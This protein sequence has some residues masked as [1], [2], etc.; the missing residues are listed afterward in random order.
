MIE[1]D[2]IENPLNY[3]DGYVD[4]PHGPGWGIVIDE[5][6]LEKYATGKKLIIK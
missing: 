4:I 2:L 3:H 5:D 6:A 1:D